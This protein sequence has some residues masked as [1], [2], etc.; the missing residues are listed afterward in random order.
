MTWLYHA[1]LMGTL[2]SRLAGVRRIIW[3][4]R[5]SDIDFS[6]YAPM[7]R[8]IATLLAWLSWLPWAVATNSHAGR[9]VHE[10]LGYRPRRWAFLPNGFDSEQ[11]KPDP[12]DRA[13][14]R[15][16]LGL[17]EGDFVIGMVARVDP[18]KD[19]A[20]FLD[21]VQIAAGKH[22][23]LRLVLV[24]KDT[25]ELS[26][27]QGL[28]RVVTALG[29]RRDVP[30]LMRMFD[31]IVLPS[32]YGEGFPNVV[33]EALASG[34]PCVVTD[35]GDA[36]FVVGEAGIVVPPRAP[37]A[38]AAAIESL[39]ARPPEQLRALA[40][41]G[42]ERIERDFSISSCLE[43]TSISFARRPVATESWGYRS[44][45]EFQTLNAHAVDC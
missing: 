34:V 44:M 17:A 29:E 42:R 7:T 16:E 15:R 30:Q 3:N 33:G 22:P 12:A 11:W 20:G 4:I 36:G 25:Q 45:N 2:A 10:A 26:V 8:K 13:A 19:H 24:G 41:L 43:A 35:T 23:R 27:P 14:V 38:V 1:D 28:G 5:C 9:R 6:R 21:A 31:V 39:I 18:Q 40:A 32:A 37:A